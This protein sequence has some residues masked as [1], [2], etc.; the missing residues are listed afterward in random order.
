MRL[1]SFKTSG[2]FAALAIGLATL[3]LPAAAQAEPGDKDRGGPH[4]GR[5]EGRGGNGGGGNRGGSAPQVQTQPPRAAP[6]A[7]GPRNWGGDRN[8][9]AA[10]RRWRTQRPEAGE[11][12]GRDWNGGSVNRPAPAFRNR[13]A[14]TMPE[15]A[16]PPPEQ[17]RP[18]LDAQPR[19]YTD[20]DRNRSY[21]PRQQG[22][23]GQRWNGQNGDRDRTRERDN[24]VE[25]R[26]SGDRSGSW[27]RQRSGTWS[28]DW[29]RDNR[30]D[31]RSWRNTN[32]HVYHLGHYRAP[33]R[34]WSYRR[35]SIGFFLQPLFF[36]STYWI[37]DPWMY[38]LPPAYGP[39]RWVRYYDDA[40]LVDIY[41]GQVVDVIYDFFW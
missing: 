6:Q 19:A 5:F 41:D 32:R 11:R 37:D 34:D 16:S 39:Y 15:R 14:D 27:D 31:W 23:D 21:T 33:Y 18:R 28:R 26:W 3:A 9:D 25:R 20:R 1:K 40:L 22:W 29:R 17:A 30:Y 35:L 8:G 2:G 10:G 13:A 7:E 38:R 4:Q 24:R 36:G 12:Y